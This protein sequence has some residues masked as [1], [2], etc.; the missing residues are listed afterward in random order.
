M[1]TPKQF[2]ALVLTMALTLAAYTAAAAAEMTAKERKTDVTTPGH[3]V[4]TAGRDVLG[5]FAPLFA[6]ANDDIL[7]GEVWNDTAIPLK[8]K[9]IITV[10]SLMAMGI[11]DSSIVYHLSTAKKYG[12]TREEIA[13]IVTHAAFYVGWPKAWAV[14]R[15]AKDVWNEEQS[16]ETGKDAHQ[17]AMIFPIGAPNDAFAKYFSGKSWL[18][19]ISTT[20]VRIFNVTFEPGCRNNWHVHNAEKGGGQI[21]VGVAGRGYYQEWGKDPIEIT[22]GVCVNIPA[23]VKHWHGAAADSWFSHLSIE[24]PGENPS[25]QWLEPVTDQDYAKLR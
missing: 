4:Q 24:A 9:S 22:P 8:T 15:L 10:T 23:G 17:A 13:A 14:F 5:D 6:H 20:Q 16:P 3:I 21:L 19:P 1:K 18:A 11:T 12:V 7:F 2:G 25:N